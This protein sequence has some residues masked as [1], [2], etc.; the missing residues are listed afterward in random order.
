[1]VWEQGNGTV[2]RGRGTRPT[3][4]NCVPE[5]TAPSLEGWGDAAG[6]EGSQGQT[7]EANPLPKSERTRPT[8]SALTGGSGSSQTPAFLGGGDSQRGGRDTGI[9]ENGVGVGLSPAFGGREG[10]L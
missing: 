5:A 8:P 3:P 6:H 9:W 4:R 1:M 10:E 2:R 7:R